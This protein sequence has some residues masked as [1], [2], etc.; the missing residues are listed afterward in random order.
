NADNER[1]LPCVPLHRHFPFLL[2]AFTEI[3]TLDVDEITFPCFSDFAR[4]VHGLPNLCFLR[5]RNLGW[6]TMGSIP[7]C[8]KHFEGWPPHPSP[9]ADNLRE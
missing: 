6:I 3:S 5:C 9:F 8:M 4:M 1:H 2:S 7:S